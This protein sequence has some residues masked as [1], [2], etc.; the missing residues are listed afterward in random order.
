LERVHAP[1]IAQ[2][3]AKASRAARFLLTPSMMPPGQ[4]V[5]VVDDNAD[6]RGFMRE[7]L[8]IAGYEVDVAENGD[9]ALERMRS[10]TAHVVITDIFMPDRDGLE[11]IDA[12]KREFP[13]AGI[14][15]ISGDRTT[16]GDTDYLS[17]AKI[18]GAH[19]ALRKPIT[20]EAL[21][22]AVRRAGASEAR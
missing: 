10:R 17:V 7:L 21:Y 13:Q 12:V 18:A 15:A 6:L 2:S 22:D 1:T 9:Q 8:E 14:V 5:L 11:T 3:A 4:R 20:P 19:C 16:A